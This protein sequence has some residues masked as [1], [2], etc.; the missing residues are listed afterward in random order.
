M[1]NKKRVIKLLQD[2]VRIDSQN[3]PGNEA[4]IGRFVKNYLAKLGLK[5]KI[6]EFKPGRSNIIAYYGNPKS[7]SSLL[8]TP[9]LDTVPK[10]TSW[11]YDPFGA[12]I[13]NGRMYG[14]GATDCKAN[15]AVSLEAMRSLVEDNVKLHYLLIFAA[16]ADEETGSASGL[17]P[18]LKKGI[19]RPSA[20][21]VLDAD[22]FGIV[23]TQKGLIH[24]KVKI[25][26]KRAHGAYPW[27]GRNAIDLAV[28][29]LADLKK[30]GFFPEARA[31]YLRE[32][33]V[34]VGTIKGGD[35][36][37]IVADACEFEL[38]FRFLPGMSGQKI[39]DKIKSVVR[40]YAAEY[41]I[42]IESIQKPFCITEKHTLVAALKAA[43]QKFK[44]KP[45]VK[46][47]EGATTITFF[48]DK[49][50]PAVASGFGSERCAHTPDEYVVIDNLYK[51]ALVLEEF[52]R[53]Y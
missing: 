4:R 31:R 20:A 14:L 13:K 2:L 37:N 25:K 40:K 46:G 27:L 8:I 22:D 1:I 30:P 51:G 23:V 36:V 16:T 15:I 12:A 38:D 18:L 3:P 35:K 50:I 17:I 32:P 43:M 28:K 49:K 6:Y 41:K 7:K 48:Q 11:K 44:I 34:N 42:E 26:G 45:H 10:G 29:I 9:H 19:L 5:V 47:S 52:L 39:T 21:L 53:R 24:L 33:T